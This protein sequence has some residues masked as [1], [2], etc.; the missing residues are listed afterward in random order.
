MPRYITLKLVNEQGTP[1]PWPGTETPFEIGSEVAATPVWIGVSADGGDNQI[2][3]LTADPQTILASWP[4]LYQGV[5]LNLVAPGDDSPLEPGP[6]EYVYYASLEEFNRLVAACCIADVV[7]DSPAESPAE[8]PAPEEPF[9]IMMR[10]TTS[11]PDEE[12]AFFMGLFAPAQ[13][14]VD[15]GDGGAEEPFFGDSEIPTH[16]YATPRNYTV[17][18]RF[19]PPAPAVID[20]I[21][22]VNV[23]LTY[24]AFSPEYGS[25]GLAMNTLQ[26]EGGQLDEAGIDFATWE[27]VPINTVILANNQFTNAVLGLLPTGFTTLNLN[28][29]NLG[30]VN[31][32]DILAGAATVGN[33]FM[34][35]CQL[36]AINF[37]GMTNDWIALHFANNLLEGFNIGDISVFALGDLNLSG[38]SLPQTDIDAILQALDAQGNENG[39]VNLSGQTPNMPPSIAG[40][41]AVGSLE[42]KFWTVT[43]DS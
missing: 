28:G 6:G 24:F 4:H 41:V 12:F 1:H 30:T 40:A 33:I 36:T 38:N 7:E 32:G 43:V 31:L 15:W 26:L 39:L 35:N 19:E 21:Q 37:A 16:A 22:V 23:P 9:D 34:D 5:Q 8:S 18:L 27:F 2:Y 20:T 25:S 11:A 17:R 29:N 3:P 10:L 14:Y 42:S 13:F